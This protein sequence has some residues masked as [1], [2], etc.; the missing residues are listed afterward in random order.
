VDAR[1]VL[2]VDDE[3]DIRESLRDA[4][5]DEGY[6]VMLASNGKEALAL[7]PK[8][9]RPCAIILDLIMPIMSG[10][11]FYEAMRAVPQLADIPVLISTSDP[12]RA[13]TRVPVMRKPINLDRLLMSVAALFQKARPPITTARS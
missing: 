7:L 3:A 6:S 12:S 4:L 5:G 10:M 2:V 11:E 13:P 8:V 1:T 9:P